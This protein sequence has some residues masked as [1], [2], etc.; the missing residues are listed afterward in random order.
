MERATHNIDADGKILGR[1][2]VE[3]AVLLRGKN[4]A[5]FTPNI[6]GGDSVVVTNV[7]K[8]KVT[9]NKLEDKIY[10][11]HTRYPGSLKSKNLGTLM[12]E[13]PAEVLTKAVRNM[14]PN[15]KLRAPMLKRLIIK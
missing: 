5:T 1:L 2:A 9:G 6:D 14:L 10:Y 12:K 11:K 13:N 8:M 3:I 7:G 15:N 4:K